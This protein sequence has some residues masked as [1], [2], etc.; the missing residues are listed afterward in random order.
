MYRVFPHL[1]CKWAI[2]KKP[3]LYKLEIK[4]A[5]GDDAI[6]LPIIMHFL[7]GRSRTSL[8]NSSICYLDLNLDL[9]LADIWISIASNKMLI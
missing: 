7:C 6:K 2:W 4:G 5:K 1:L 3:A 8:K 9:D